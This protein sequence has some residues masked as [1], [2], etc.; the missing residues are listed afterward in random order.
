[1][2]EPKSDT[3]SLRSKKKQRAQQTR[4]YGFACSNCRRKKARCN[5]ATPACDKCIASRETCE[6]DRGP[7]VAYAASLEKRLK[8]F[9][10]RFEKLRQ[11]S[12][13][14]ERNAL[15]QEPFED[16]KPERTRAPS[17]LMA[18]PEGQQNEVHEPETL[19]SPSPAAQ[20]EPPDE[21][22]IGA[23]GRICFYGKT[24]HY[25]VD[26]E[27]DGTGVELL[28]ESDEQQALNMG[29]STA[30]TIYTTPELNLFVDSPAMPQLL[31]EISSESLNH[32]L[33]AYWCWSHHLHLVLNKRLFLRDLHTSGPSVTPFLV[34]AVLAQAAR[35]ST[36]PE[37]S[38]LG[39][40]FAA[41]ALHLLP[42]DIDKG[43]SIPTVQGLLILSAR[44]CAC[45]RIS[46]GWLYSGMAFR[47]MRDLGIHIEPRK[48]GYLSR[49]FSEEDLALRQQ[50]FWS[51]FTWDKTMSLCLGRAPIIHDTIDVPSRDS[52]L[53]G[54]ETD[55]EQWVPVLGNQT[56]ST[57]SFIE[58][59]S[60]GSARFAAYCRLCTIIDGVLD[61]L[62]CRPHQSKQDHLLAFLDTTIGRLQQWSTSLPPGLFISPDSRVFL[63]P[64]IHI[65][66]LNLTY[67]ATM[68]LLCRPYR[69]ISPQAKELCTKAAQMIDTLFTLHVRQFG[70]RFITYLQTYTMFVAC[71]INV[72]DL[73]EN[74]SNSRDLA[75][76]AEARE[77]CLA[78]AQEASV[79]LNFGLEVLRQAG[80]TPSAARCAAVIVQLLRQWSN[81]EAN[82][83]MCNQR[84]RQRSE[85][86]PS[87]P[88]RRQSSMCRAEA[89]HPS[90]SLQHNAHFRTD[91]LSMQTQS[92]GNESMLFPAVESTPAYAQAHGQAVDKQPSPDISDTMNLGFG[93]SSGLQPL[94]PDGSAYSNSHVPNFANSGIETPMRWL[95][96]N[97]HDDGSWML[98]MDFGDNISL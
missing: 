89:R 60:L 62:Y 43:S 39:D 34:S 12:T 18:V 27:D 8:A 38:H 47:M 44:E 77:E 63:C 23:D 88:F 98:M 9:E 55:E 58:Q 15:I 92:N 72:L 45:G 61:G 28:P 6:Y 83:K 37:S 74:E 25:H 59:K 3:A 13:V 80:A 50:V 49:Q 11:S 67:H 97:I 64:P 17:A 87:P 22:S 94:Q 78:L 7:S 41:R 76:G 2:V 93:S 1:M 19:S 4:R 91:L 65:L 53:D 75:T 14:D 35:Y 10:E 56:E 54:A 71:T 29:V 86:Q 79:R 32:L 73:K 21:T 33:D 84:Q 5:G 24:S 48:M 42:S 30:S 36:R 95:P 16:V 40:H 51:C 31:S 66:L 82:S 26:L 85:Q 69:N 52:L 81:K 96:D 68:I 70:F 57:A 90:R 20:N 46:Q